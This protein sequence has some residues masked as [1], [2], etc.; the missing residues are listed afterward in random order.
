[1]TARWDEP[2]HETGNLSNVELLDRG[3]EPTELR[4]LTDLRAL[5]AKSASHGRVH[6]IWVRHVMCADGGYGFVYSLATSSRD[7]QTWRGAL[8]DIADLLGV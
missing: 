3:W 6:E 1:M 8:E 4:R 5:A 2:L 7:F